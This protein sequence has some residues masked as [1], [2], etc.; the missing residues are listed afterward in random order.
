[1]KAIPSDRDEAWMVSL[2]I[3]DCAV[4]WEKSPDVVAVRNPNADNDGVGQGLGQ[5]AA[6]VFQIEYTAQK[7]KKQ[8]IL[9]DSEE[10]FS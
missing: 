9:Q 3:N 8:S 7:E 2:E 5:S 6:R 4:N 1:M 10:S